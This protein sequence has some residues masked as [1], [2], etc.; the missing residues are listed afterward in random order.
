MSK[1]ITFFLFAL[2][3]MSILSG[4]MEGGGGYA[5]TELSSGITAAAVTIPVDSTDG[6]LSADYI[7]IGDETILYTGKTAN[8][9][10]GATRGYLDTEATAHA[11]NTN[12]YTTDASAVNS[13]LGFNIAATAD[14]MGWWAAITIPWNFLVKTVPRIAVINYSFLSGELAIIGV[15]WYA[16]VGG[17]IV[18][19]ALYI[20]GGRRV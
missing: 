11:D 16:M 19:L 14:S 20:A 15:L 10:T 6:F 5:V 8:S 18:S 17:L 4:V 2:I 3:G 7:N 1:L 13:A 12:V 9:F